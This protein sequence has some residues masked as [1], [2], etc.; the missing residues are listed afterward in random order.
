MSFR[1][2][3]NKIHRNKTKKEMEKTKLKRSKENKR[4]MNI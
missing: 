2:N 1:Y 4:N 3:N